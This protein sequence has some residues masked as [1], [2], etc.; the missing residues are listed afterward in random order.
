MDNRGGC[1]PNLDLCQIGVR[2]CDAGRSC[3][4]VCG[5]LKKD[6][7]R[8]TNQTLKVFRENNGKFSLSRPMPNFGPP[9]PWHRLASACTRPW[10]K[11]TNLCVL[12]K[13]AEFVPPYH[14]WL[15]YKHV[16][17]IPSQLYRAIEMNITYILP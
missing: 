2:Q 4:Y 11:R 3:D 7:G 10:I 12:Q 8:G 1:R 13:G 14:Y 16:F 6:M 9:M 17:L 5:L 15:T